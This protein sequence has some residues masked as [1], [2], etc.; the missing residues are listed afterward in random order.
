M[1]AGQGP[2]NYTTSIDAEKTALEC[3][4]MLMKHGARN[5]ALSVGEDRNPDGLDFAIQLPWGVTRAYSV[6]IN[7]AG[8][9]RALKKAVAARRI[10]PGFATPDQARRVAWRVMKDWLEVQIA[11][12]E[13]GAVELEQVMLPY[14]RV[15]ADKTVYSVWVADEM[16]QLEGGRS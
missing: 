7:I 4:T 6:P 10:R 8:T 12:I 14:M 3:V 15:A 5:V 2:L 13:A 16:R 11:L 9:E 1:A